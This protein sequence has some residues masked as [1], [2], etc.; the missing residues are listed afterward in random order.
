MNG[1][2]CRSVYFRARSHHFC[3]CVNMLM[4]NNMS[5]YNILAGRFCH[6]YTHAANHTPK[7]LVEIEPNPSVV[8]QSTSRFP[9]NFLF[10][11]F[12]IG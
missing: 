12:P 2:H 3:Y 10:I 5:S 11:F 1:F 8:S 7:A 6:T 9:R 4:R